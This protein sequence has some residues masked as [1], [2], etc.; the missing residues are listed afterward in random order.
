VVTNFQS[1]DQSMVR[2]FSL[3]IQSNGKKSMEVVHLPVEKN[4]LV[5]TFVL[6]NAIQEAMKRS[7]VIKNARKYFLVDTNAPKIVKTN[8]SAHHACCEETT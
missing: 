2:R 1:L 6:T 3:N 8:A 7:N 4:L 5:D